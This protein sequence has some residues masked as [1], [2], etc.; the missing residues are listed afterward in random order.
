M[1]EE[2]FENW[3]SRWK[4]KLLSIGGRLVLINSV[5]SSLPMFMMFFLEVP[6]G[7]LKRLDYYR[8]HFFWKNDRHKKKYRLARWEIVCM[9]KDQE[10]LG[11]LDLD[12]KKKCLL[13]NGF[14][15]NEDGLW[16]HVLRNKYLRYKMLTQL[17]KK[18]GDSQFWSGLMGIKDH[19]V[20]WGGSKHE[21]LLLTGV[22]G[23]LW[24]L[25][26]SRNNAVFDK[27]RSKSFML[28]HTGFDYGPSCSEVKNVNI[29]SKRVAN[30]KW[31]QCNYSLRLDG[32]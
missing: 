9:P 12:T 30:L 3:L 19:W 1:V 29:Y 24:V 31:W 14:S 15:T 23:I 10:G 25:W 16:Q 5:L 20:K 21:S 2:K 7:V 6:R 26:L 28:E 32:L 27:C 17:E 13:D 18:L 11:I 8:T 4:G 22:A